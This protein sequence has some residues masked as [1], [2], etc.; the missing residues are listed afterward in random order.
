[1]SLPK[2]ITLET[3]TFYADKTGIPFFDA[4]RLI[5]VAHFFF[6]TASAEI[7]DKGGDRSPCSCSF[8]R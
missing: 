4:A 7:E 2:K 1:M 6:G 8:L 5:G 3:Q